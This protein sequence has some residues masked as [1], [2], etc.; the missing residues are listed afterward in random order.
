MS[1][2]IKATPIKLGSCR[3]IL[4]YSWALP[5]HSAG[6]TCCYKA[7]RSTV[8]WQLHKP[9]FD[10]RPYEIALFAA[11]TCPCVRLFPTGELNMTTANGLSVSTKGSVP[12]IDCSWGRT[13]TTLPV[14]V[15][16]YRNTATLFCFNS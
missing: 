9:K 11:R 12:F 2:Y 10:L 14:F 16:P 5:P 1:A 4:A 7:I 15:V 8:V 13:M 3:N 6:R